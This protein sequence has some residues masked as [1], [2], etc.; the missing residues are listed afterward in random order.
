ML[1]P[2]IIAGGQG[3][4][5]W[6]VSRRKNPKQVRPFLGQKTLLNKTFE[7]LLR[8]VP[9]EHIFLSTTKDLLAEAKKETP[10]IL[11]CHI[12]A[13]PTRRD[14]AA[15]LGLALC[16]LYGED[17]DSAFV[18]INS[19]NY[20]KDEEEYARI[21]RLGERVIEKNP[22]QVLLIGVK[23]EYPE[24]G[25]GYIRTGEEFQTYGNDAVYEIVRFVE[26]PDLE[27]AKIFLQEKNYFWN[28]TLIISKTAHFLSLYRK[29]LPAMFEK[30]QAI[31]DCLG[32]AAEGEIIEKIFPQINPISID[33]GILEKE[34]GMLVLPAAFG[35][36][37][38]GHWKAIWSLLAAAEHDNV[39]IGK[40]IHIDSGG[41]LIY[42]SSDKLVA[43]I[44]LSNML[45]VDTGDAIMMCPKERAQEVKK[46]VKKLEEQGMGEYL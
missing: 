3:T 6:P 21:L 16:R 31:A 4:R 19:D 38:V 15:A 10:G 46:L 33:Y 9:K 18:Y 2:I 22:K 7:R 23:P 37:D 26:K 45:I 5:L 30:L 14:T 44:G 27:K 36:A 13:E 29:H 20:V 12:S 17:K 8:V 41:N 40:H 11:E 32:T 25:Y 1:F 24:I 43:T 34:K 42:S 39:E 35:W 28:P